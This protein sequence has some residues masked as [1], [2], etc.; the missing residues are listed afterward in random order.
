MT[1]KQIRIL[2]FIRRK[3]RTL[4]QIAQKLGFATADDFMHSSE[5]DLLGGEFD[6]LIN[7]YHAS[8]SVDEWVYSII[9]PGIELLDGR[10]LS[11]YRW[12][13]PVAIS[14]VSLVISIAAL[15]KSFL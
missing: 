12:R 4:K 15:V 3:P 2:R 9:L 7:V 11:N 14:I 8:D 5:Y 1:N 13:V 6:K 10:D